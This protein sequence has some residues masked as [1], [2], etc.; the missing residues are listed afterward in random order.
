[1]ENLNAKELIIMLRGEFERITVQL[2]K[3][4]F[5]IN[6]FITN[7]TILIFIYY[8]II[9]LYHIGV[10]FFKQGVKK[11]KNMRKKRSFQVEMIWR[12]GR[13]LDRHTSQRLY[14]Q[15]TFNTWRPSVSLDSHNL[16]QRI[17][18]DVFTVL[19]RCTPAAPFCLF[20]MWSRWYDFFYYIH[21]LL[22]VFYKYI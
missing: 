12:F 10:W 3:I 8:Q 22:V 7:I 15:N 4:E 16:V 14:G 17:G 13:I 2:G 6:F 11:P 18:T 5:R 21:F 20:S 1:M 19:L 9:N